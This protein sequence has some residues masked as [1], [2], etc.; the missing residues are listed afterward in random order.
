MNSNNVVFNK[1]R[2]MHNVPIS[3]HLSHAEKK[4]QVDAE[5]KKLLNIAYNDGTYYIH[6]P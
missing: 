3:H 2:E 6:E 1:A 5:R 4:K